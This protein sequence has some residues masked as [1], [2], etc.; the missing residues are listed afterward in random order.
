MAA[1][2]H[3]H[4]L[5]PHREV[6]VDTPDL[7]FAKVETELGPLYV[8]QLTVAAAHRVGRVPVGYARRVDMNWIGNLA[9]DPALST[10]A[11]ERALFVDTETTGLS[12]G[13]GTVAFLV[14]IAFFQEDTMI[15]EQLFIKRLGEEAPMLDHLRKRIEAAS[16][17]VT[18]NGKSFDMPLLRTRFQ[19]AKQQAPIEP[20]HLDLVHVARRVHGKTEG[21]LRLINLERDVLGFERF[22]DTP[23][24]EVS[25]CYLHFLRTGETRALLG[26]VEHNAWDVFT[27]ASLLG[28]YGESLDGTSLRGDDLARVAKTFTRSKNHELAFDTASRAIDHGSVLGAIARAEVARVSGDKSQALRDWEWAHAQEEG[29]KTRLALAKLYEHHTKDPARALEV[30]CAGTGES[31][32]ALEKR[33]ARLRAKIARKE[34]LA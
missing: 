34:P 9:L 21:G 2:M 8:R 23:S 30:A 31:D 26:V 7:P 15:L 1:I 13:T 28:L 25:E 10:C 18:Y 32:D 12:G 29:P 14:G 19:M 27:M 22:D 6:R 33:L 20:P 4:A 16:M 3:K 5:A 24:G 17:I 11:P